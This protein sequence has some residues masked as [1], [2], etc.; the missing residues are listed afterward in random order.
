[1]LPEAC[2]SPQSDM[3]CRYILATKFP[4]ETCPW[5]LVSALLSFTIA[6]LSASGMGKRELQV[7]CFAVVMSNLVEGNGGLLALVY[8]LDYVVTCRLVQLGGRKW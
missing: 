2:D 6:G 1:M 5:C 8:K 7:G 4:G 3:C